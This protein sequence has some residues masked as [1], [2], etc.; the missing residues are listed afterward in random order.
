[1][2]TTDS[3]ADVLVLQPLGEVRLATSPDLE[4]HHRP[5][6]RPAETG[7]HDAHDGEARGWRTRAESVVGSSAT[8]GREEQVI[9]K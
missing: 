2:I 7:A 6:T 4:E 8:L 1:M 3:A 5:D 9:M